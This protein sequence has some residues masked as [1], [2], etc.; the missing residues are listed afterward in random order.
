MKHRIF[1]LSL[2]SCLWSLTSGISSAERLTDLP[3]I[4]GSAVDPAVDLMLLNDT[5]AGTAGSKK[6]TLAEL[7]NVSSFTNGNFLAANSVEIAQINGL[8]TA[9]DSK[10]DDTQLS[11]TGGANKVLQADANGNWRLGPVSN[12]NAWDTGLGDL[13]MPDKRKIKFH[14][15][16]GNYDAGIFNWG[17]HNGTENELIIESVGRIAIAP[18]KGMQF[19]PN[20]AQRYQRYIQ[21]V[22]GNAN[23]GLGGPSALDENLMPSGAFLMQTKAWNGGAP[24]E[25]TI[26]MQGIALGGTNSLIRFVDGAS[27]LT[28]RTGDPTATV[29]DMAGT[30]IAEIYKDGIWSP[31]TAPAFNTLTATSN[32]FTQTCSKY[33]TVQI[34]KLTLGATNTLEIFDAIDG[35]RGVIYA[36][37]DSTGSRSISLPAGSMTANGVGLV[38]SGANKTDRIAWEYNSGIYY[39]TLETNL[40]AAMDSS[41]SAFLTASGNSGD[42]TISSAINSLVVSLKNSGTTP[43]TLWEK[44]Y[45]LFPFVGGTETKHRYEL[46][47]GTMLG[48]FSGTV[49]HTGHSTGTIT[50]DGSTG[51]FNSNFIPSVSSD[52]NSIGVYAYSR[53]TLP[54]EGG[55][56]FGAIGTGPVSK[57]ALRRNGIY[58]EKIGASD[59]ATVAISVA[60][61]FRGLLYVNRSAASGAGAVYWGKVGAGLGTGEQ[62]ATTASAG[63]CNAAIAFLGSFYVGDNAYYQSNANLGLGLITQSLSPAERT[64]LKTII[65]TFQTALGRANP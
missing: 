9:L 55:Y 4:T 34:A 65:D 62:V 54:T 17:D 2:A 49:T 26:S 44:T 30:P 45:R 43:N 57:F 38:L 23:T 20:D 14:D 12:G 18:Y 60:S 7:V 47:A 48:S 8:Q 19:G 21:M 53:T 64:S 41:A 10:V 29:G 13:F 25:N 32:V 36:T 3:A 22:S 27:M 1:L 42:A 58:A 5:S 56:F 6:I 35:M 40:S 11:T 31:G 24:S 63:N 59:A 15:Q 39:W 37:Q 52:Q 16:S 28:N 33:K 50:G 46:K 51:W 61:D